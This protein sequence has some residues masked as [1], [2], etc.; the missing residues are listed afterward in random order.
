MRC[1]VA[2]RH[3]QTSHRGATLSQR[4]DLALL[5]PSSTSCGGG[6]YEWM[7]DLHKEEPPASYMHHWRSAVT[8]VHN[9]Q[10]STHVQ[11]LQGR[12][13]AT[14]PSRLPQRRQ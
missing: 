7:L 12:P 9:T 2:T 8:G 13:C 6:V 11:R 10:A 1:N 4:A 14:R 5:G 3:T